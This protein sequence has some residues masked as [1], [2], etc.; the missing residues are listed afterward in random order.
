[1]FPASMNNH[2]SGV[3][4]MNGSARGIALVEYGM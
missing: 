4:V 2:P 1:M 3:M